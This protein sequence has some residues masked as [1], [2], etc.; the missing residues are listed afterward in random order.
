MLAILSQTPV[1]FVFL[2]AALL[3]AVTLHEFMHAWTANYFGDPTA[4]H[5]GRI[6][7]NPVRHL[8]MFGTLAILLIGIG[9]GKPV[10]VNENNFKNP[11]LG[12]AVTS[13]AGPMTNLVVAI[14]FSI[15]VLFGVV[16]IDSLPYLFF[17]LIVRINVLLMILNMLPIPPLD[18][19]KVLYYFLP[20]SVDI[21]KLETYGPMILM[22]LIF[23]SFL[24][25]TGGLFSI[26]FSISEPILNLLGFK[27]ILF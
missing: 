27:E 11:R 25:P 21:V 18:G 20:R 10:Q 26:I 22:A 23:F 17:F 13:L 24:S 15:P 16:Q 14:L 19:S 6:S 4:K 12:S 9:W 5:M 7:L 1:L 8:D 3:I 2:V